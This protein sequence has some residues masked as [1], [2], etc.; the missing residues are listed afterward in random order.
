[1]DDKY[2]KLKTLESLNMYE[3]GTLMFVYRNEDFTQKKL[4]SFGGGSTDRKIEALKSLTNKGLLSITKMGSQNDYQITE[5]G[6]GMAKLIIHE[7]KG[8]I[9]NKRVV[10]QIEK[11]KVSSWQK[12]DRQV[13]EDFHKVLEPL[14]QKGCFY[15]LK[16]DKYDD[17]NNEE[18]KAHCKKIL[19]PHAV[20]I[21]SMMDKSLSYKNL[22]D[23]D[24]A[25][26]DADKSKYREMKVKKEMLIIKNVMDASDKIGE[27]LVTEIGYGGL[28]QVYP[29]TNIEYQKL[30]HDY[31][32]R[33]QNIDDLTTKYLGFGYRI[34]S[35]DIAL[36]PFYIFKAFRYDGDKN[37][38]DKGKGILYQTTIAVDRVIQ[39]DTVD[40]PA[41]FEHI[42]RHE[43]GKEMILID[44]QGSWDL[45]YLRDLND[46][47]DLDRDIN[48]REFHLMISEPS[49]CAKIIKQV[50]NALKK[51]DY[52]PADEMPLWLRQKIRITP[53]YSVTL[54]AYTCPR[55]DLIKYFESRGLFN[56][57]KGC[58]IYEI[59]QDK[60]F[61]HKE[62]LEEYKWYEDGKTQQEI[63]EI[64][65]VSQTAIGNHLASIK[66]EISRLIGNEYEKWC[67]QKYS[68]DNQ[69]K[70]VVRNGRTGYPDLTV[71]YIEGSV[72]VVSCKCY[73][74]LRNTFSIP[75]EELSPEINECLRLTNQGLSVTLVL[76]VFN[77]AI[78]KRLRKYLDY[79]DMPKNIT[80]QKNDFMERGE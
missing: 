11:E 16:P 73:T 35:G 30:K 55:E 53:D 3:R 67:E 60:R 76:D 31:E 20:S 40:V 17:W 68:E 15:N 46:E 32:M 19:I 25:K 38:Y 12:R 51:N 14:K 24:E 28:N 56:Y 72:E 70:N 48:E 45:D 44:I 8:I 7:E 29:L 57:T 41:I 62:W 36:Y 59:Q 50:I 5:E 27:M 4:Q 80:L 54:D 52:V 77:T 74:D 18:F 79:C 2:L 66:G 78:R 69:V 39:Y 33:G 1:M 65:N 6:K 9:P 64:R 26:S 37:Y 10:E 13:A 43:N 49:D 47:K 75:V 21:T 61:E 42:P 23:I 63:A 34:V 71:Y 22:P 58:A